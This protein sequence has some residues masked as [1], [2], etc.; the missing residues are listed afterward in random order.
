MSDHTNRDLYVNPKYIHRHVGGKIK[1]IDNNTYQKY[2]TD[3][4]RR[5]TNLLPPI[6]QFS[7]TNKQN[8]SQDQ[9]SSNN[10]NRDK[11]LV[12]IPN[13]VSNNNTFNQPKVQSPEYYG[14]HFEPESK[15][16]DPFVGFLHNKGLLDDG[17]NKRR[18]TTD[19]I[20]IDS[21]F[22][23]KEPSLQIDS[24]KQLSQDSLDM[25]IGSNIIFV[26]HK[27]HG[28]EEGDL[29]TMNGV[30]TPVSTVR[31]VGDNGTPTFII[32]AGSNVMKIFY[33]HGL[34]NTY[35]GTEIEVQFLGIRGDRGNLETTSYLGNMPTNFINSTHIIRLSLL[36]EDLNSGSD[37]LSTDPTF[38]DFSPNHFFVILPKIMHNPSPN[39]AYT[40]REYNYKI[41]FLSIGG[42]PLYLLNADYPILSNRRHGFHVISN[43]TE[44]SYTFTVATT[45]V[46]STFGGGNCIYV[47]KIILVNSGF[48]N[49][50][51]Y[52]IDLGKTFNDVVSAKLVS[53][54]F[55]NSERSVRGIDIRKNNK[56]YWNDIDDGDHLYSIE[57]PS[58]NYEPTSLTNIIQDL[59]FAVPRINSGQDIGA[60]YQPNHYMQLDI[61]INTD[62]VTFQ[63]FKEFILAVP[64]IAITPQ[65]A[66]DS[67]LDNNPVDTLYILTLNHP[68]HGMTQI[69]LTILISGAIEH[70]GI[71]ASILNSEYIV[72]EIIDSNTYTITLPRFNLLSTR[73]ESKGGNAFTILIPD[74]FRLRFDVDDTIGELLGFRN[75][76]S[77]NSI[78]K[79]A[80]TIKNSDQYAFDTDKSVTGETIII[81]H[82][83][84]RLSGFNYIL[85]V[86]SPLETL[87]HNGPIKT[88]F[89]KIQLCDLPGR[90]LFNNFVSTA[91]FY[92]DP[93]YELSQLQVAFYTPDGF[94]FDFNGLDHSYTIEIVTVRDIPSATQINTN[95]GKNYNSSN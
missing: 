63:S 73:T 35:N 30:T 37:I 94:L 41:Q 81:Q 21:S 64:I 71:S 75:P 62:V 5:N 32:P 79:F 36:E 24:A 54:E 31:T 26:Q 93:I 17:T 70:F 92:Q 18:F 83:S 27:K 50:N 43:I 69:G 4:I 2:Q 7:S 20:S 55:P 6:P 48:P 58:G 68:G 34:P 74:T 53:L 77:E 91:K 95:T 66:S 29:I 19:Y 33:Q 46:S 39:P 9:R 47:A 10:I 67:N 28:F 11:N 76:G 90:V 15:R 86:A 44:N 59:F 87:I 16:Y 61:N 3:L 88:A 84:I 52:I 14:L 45:A 60:T 38:L 65:I 23:E 25:N 22:R 13:S 72:T 49:P 80:S 51:N 85:M 12:N 82:N 40:L 42:I 78:T 1:P 89:A 57:I 8:N 56:I